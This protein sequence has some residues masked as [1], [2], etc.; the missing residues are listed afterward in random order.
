[1][2]AMFIVLNNFI[3]EMWGSNSLGPIG[4][5]MRKKKRVSSFLLPLVGKGKKIFWKQISLNLSNSKN[6][7]PFYGFEKHF[8]L[9]ILDIT[10]SA[11]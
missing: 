5:I 1:M 9:C 4:K 7:I 10:I 3:L 2:Y 6:I 11:S 8:G